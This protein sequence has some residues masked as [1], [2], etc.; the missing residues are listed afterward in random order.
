LEVKSLNSKTEFVEIKRFGKRVSFNLITITTLNKTKNDFRIGFQ[1][2]K[3]VGKAV[4]RN[5]IRRQLRHLFSEVFNKYL[6]N[7]DNNGL[8]VLIYINPKIENF[9]FSEYKSFLEKKFDL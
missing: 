7:S 8:W 2:N 4:F 9:D 1:I 6:S 5:K 3:K